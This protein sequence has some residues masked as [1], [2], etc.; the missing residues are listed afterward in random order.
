MAKDNLSAQARHLFSLGKSST[1]VAGALGITTQWACVIRWRMQHPGYDVEWMRKARDG[2]YG[3]V[4]RDRSR[5]R[6]S[7]RYHLDPEFRAKALASS[8]KSAAKNRDAVSAYQRTYRATGRD[9][10][11]ARA[12]AAAVRKAIRQGKSPC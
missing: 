10:A 6:K 7:Q 9:T 5:A 2:K 3:E 8:A 4:E 11:A 12:A 1:E